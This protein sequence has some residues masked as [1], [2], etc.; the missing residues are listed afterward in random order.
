MLCATCNLNSIAFVLT[1]S[2]GTG[3]VVLALL[4]KDRQMGPVSSKAMTHLVSKGV[5]MPLPKSSVQKGLISVPFNH[6]LMQ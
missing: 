1:N 4:I 3:V 2:S 6:L 5:I